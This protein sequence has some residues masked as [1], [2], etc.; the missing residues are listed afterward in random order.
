MLLSIFKTLFSRTFFREFYSDLCESLAGSERDFTQI[1]LSKAI[2]LLSIPMVLEMIMESV[3]ALVDIFFVSRLGAEAVATVGITESLM[4]IIYA[5]GIGLSV[6]TTA[7]VARRIGEKRPEQAA[8]A[9]VQAITTGVAVSLVFTA[10]GIFYSKDLLRL[11][12]A[13]EE[14]VQMGYMYPAIMLG[15]NMV[16]ILL[17][18]INAVFRSSGDAAISMRV[19][20]LANILNIIL[21]PLLIFGIGPFPEMG[22]RGAA[23]ATNIGRGVAVLYQLYLLGKGKHRVQVRASQIVIRVKEMMQLVKLSL[24]AIGQYLIATSSWVVLVWVVTS[25]G[26]EVVAGYTIAIRIIL[27]ALLPA[28][29]LANAAA[30]LVGQNLGAKKP[31]RAERSAWVVGIA[32]MMFLGLVSIIFI[33]IPD[34]FIGTFIDAASEP[35]VMQ[36]GVTCLRVISFGF[37]VYALGQVMVNAINGAGDTATPIWINFIAFWVLEIPL[38]FLF[39]KVMGLDIHGVCYAILIADTTLT[40]I[41]L[42][43]FR[44]GKWKLK[45]V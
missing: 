28:W 9:A 6:G 43:V 41:A 26:E 33:A 39:A 38:A 1:P 5:I 35:V 13:S 21:D 44:R 20:W 40:L 17:F 23:V 11:M 22:I 2:L 36:S 10:V 7:L 19:L 4:T 29:G 25:L 32:N 24:G 31:D 16:I 15:G 18:I 45:V 12:G 37:F 42:A 8:V 27:F 14:T 34:A 3:F 30:T